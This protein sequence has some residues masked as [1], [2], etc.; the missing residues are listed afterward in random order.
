MSSQ[1]LLKTTDENAGDENCSSRSIRASELAQ[2]ESPKLARSR[3]DP[4]SASN[5]FSEIPNLAGSQEN[6]LRET[7]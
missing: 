5:R 2:N 3:T 1:D 6:D 7:I 4:N